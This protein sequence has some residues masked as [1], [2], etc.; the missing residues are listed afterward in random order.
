MTNRASE[1]LSSTAQFL[2]SIETRIKAA[3]EHMENHDGDTSQLHGLAGE[4]AHHTE[5]IATA[6]EAEAATPTPDP[7]APPADSGNTRPLVQAIAEHLAS[8]AP[9]A[10]APLTVGTDSPP[11]SMVVTRAAP[12]VE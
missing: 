5:G 6:I 10:V 1:L 12:T 7:V 2:R 4:M 3:I 8:Q 9:P 11:V